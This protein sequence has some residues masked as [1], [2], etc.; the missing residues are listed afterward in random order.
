M[1]DPLHSQPAAI[2][3]GGTTEDPDIVVYSA[4]NDGYVHALSGRTGKE[5]WAFIPREHLPQMTKLFF[6][7]ESSPKS[8]PG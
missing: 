7:P 6:N 1:G 8:I 3:Y 4:T 2:V 5:L